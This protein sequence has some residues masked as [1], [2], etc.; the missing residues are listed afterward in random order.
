MKNFILFLALFICG[1]SF[2][3]TSKIEKTP[4]TT[5]TNNDLYNV[6]FVIKN[7]V[8]SSEDINLINS[9][10]LTSYEG[11]RKMNDDVEVF[12]PAV[13]KT[14]ILFSKNKTLS[15]MDTLIFNN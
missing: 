9:I 4:P 12:V 8:Y 7:Y 14:I 5:F 6:S 1:I 3:Q 10:N 2:S 15:N 13:Q 11:L